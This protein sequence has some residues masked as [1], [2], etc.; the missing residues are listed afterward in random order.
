MESRSV[1]SVLLICRSSIKTGTF[2]LD[3]TD[4]ISRWRINSDFPD[5]PDPVIIEDVATLATSDGVGVDKLRFWVLRS[6]GT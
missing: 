3:F 5:P 1:P 6:R 2:S 4:W